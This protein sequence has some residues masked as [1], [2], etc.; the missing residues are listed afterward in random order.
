MDF[1][2][3]QYKTLSL[4]KHFDNDILIMIKDNLDKKNNL[5]FKFRRFY[6]ILFLLNFKNRYEI[7]DYLHNYYTI[8]RNLAQINNYKYIIQSLYL[9]DITHQCFTHNFNLYEKNFKS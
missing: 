2:L 4:Y 8:S 7:F 6:N 5:I 9:T 1:N 3:N